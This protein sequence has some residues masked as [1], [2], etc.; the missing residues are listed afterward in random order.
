MRRRRSTSAATPKSSEAP[1]PAQPPS[2]TSNPVEGESQIGQ[3]PVVEGRASADRAAGSE[4]NDID[5]AGEQVGGSAPAEGASEESPAGSPAAAGGSSSSKGTAD[6]KTQ[7]AFNEETGEINWDCPVRRFLLPRPLARL[8][9]PQARAFPQCLGGMPHGPCGEEFRAAFSCFVYSEEEPKGIECVE[10]FKGMQECFRAHPEVYGECACP[11]RPSLSQLLA[12]ATL[13]SPS[14]AAPLPADYEE[15][16]A[17]EAAAAA[18][19]AEQ[20][21]LE[22]LE[23]QLKEDPAQPFK[24]ED[25]E[26]GELFAQDGGLT[27][28]GIGAKTE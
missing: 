25:D 20:H 18:V 4:F 10:K 6:P 17:A 3:A 9:D 21:A 26:R 22:P 27:G 28:E 24:G 23:T 13:T 11:R 7:G 5:V 8:A 2:T 19:E 12:D 16:E 1:I 15:D 14:S